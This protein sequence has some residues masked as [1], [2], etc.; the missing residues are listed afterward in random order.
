MG[1]CIMGLSPGPESLTAGFGQKMGA[2]NGS[3]YTSGTGMQLVVQETPCGRPGITLFPSLKDW[4]TQPLTEEDCEGALVGLGIHCEPFQMHF[5]FF[6]CFG[7]G[8]TLG[9]V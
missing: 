2:V 1:P 6:V 8:A 7:L 4:P 3:C 5:D 9:G